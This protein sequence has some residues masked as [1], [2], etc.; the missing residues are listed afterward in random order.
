MSTEAPEG[1]LW[2]GTCLPEELFL[3]AKNDPNLFYEA[4]LWHLFYVPEEYLL[5]SGDGCRPVI[6]YQL[7]QRIEFHHPE[8]ILPSS[9][10]EHLEVLYIISKPGE[11]REHTREQVRGLCPGYLG[12]TCPSN[13]GGVLWELVFWQHFHSL[14]GPHCSTTWLP[15]W[16]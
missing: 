12:A 15:G 9:I 10:S 7:V 13:Q 16:S 3:I 1:I 11:G 2:K 4:Y 8:E 5:V 6:I 14:R